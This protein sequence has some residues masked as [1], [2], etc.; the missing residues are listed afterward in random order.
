VQRILHLT[1]LMACKNTVIRAYFWESINFGFISYINKERGRM[2]ISGVSV[3][4]KV[5]Q[6]LGELT[7]RIEMEIGEFE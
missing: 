6:V 7:A 4:P 3:V 2:F 5:S 1:T